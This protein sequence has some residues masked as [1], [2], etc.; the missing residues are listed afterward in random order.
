MTFQ[1]FFGTIYFINGYV[2]LPYLN[3][4][5]DNSKYI[6]INKWDFDKL[7]QD[8]MKIYEENIEKFK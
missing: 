7:R 6:K 4:N 3:I 8:V 5:L 2:R 1:E